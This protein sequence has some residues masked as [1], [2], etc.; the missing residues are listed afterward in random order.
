MARAPPPGGV[1]PARGATGRSGSDDHCDHEPG[2]SAASTPMLASAATW[3]AAVTPEPQYTATGAP[4]AARSA[5]NRSVSASAGR[6]VPSS[7]RFCAVGALTAPGM[8]PAR[9]STGSTSPA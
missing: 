2:Y 8:W 7:A 6:N 9:G 4:A 5:R 3:C 1:G